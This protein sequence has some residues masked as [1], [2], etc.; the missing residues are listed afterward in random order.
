MDYL[1]RDLQSNKSY[2]QP[3]LRLIPSWLALTSLSMKLNLS[4]FFYVQ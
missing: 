4:S 1:S 3:T 2:R